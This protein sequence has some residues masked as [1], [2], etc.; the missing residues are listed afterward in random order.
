[1]SDESTK[2]ASGA[3]PGPA[4]TSAA[5]DAPAPI[6]VRGLVKRYGDLTA[7]AG[8]DLT[9]RAG[10]VYGYLGPNG[11]GKTTSL[12][13]ML[14]LITPTAGTIRLFGQDPTQSV[15]ALAGVAGFVEA[16]TFYPYLTARRNLE[17]MAA[18]DGGDARD[19]VTD[20][21]E[22][23]ELT[24]RADD[25]VG[26]YSHG[27]RQR[28]GIAASLLRNPKLLL[29]DEP[30]TGLDPGGMRDMRVLI[31]RLAD[32]GM[33]VL[34]SSHL[35]NEVEELCNRV[36]IVRS[37]R[38]VYEGEISALKRG[39]ST[40]YRLETTDDERALAVCRAQVGIA[41][42][43]LEAGHITFSADENAVAALS[44]A[45]VESGALIRA[46]APQTVT[47][48]DLFFSFTEGD[49]VQE[50]AG[51]ADAAVPTTPVAH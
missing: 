6:E 35:M 7:V 20:V 29:L 41:E 3:R 1:V 51:T 24:G 32:Q 47:L 31:R 11:A 19:R 49:A 28:L 2:P 46:M 17:M 25:R 9:V 21:L 8:V 18:F 45:L 15:H 16:P 37:G 48:E 23:V 33:T 13:M 4:G 27:M 26:G 10:D 44:Q 5:T 40:L 30:A 38:I 39:A 36:A 42:V 22:T 12:R 34:L 43:K 14:G 50:M